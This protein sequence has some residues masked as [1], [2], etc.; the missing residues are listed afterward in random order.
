MNKLVSVIGPSCA[1]VLAAN[2]PQVS[3]SKVVVV[4]VV[5]VEADQWLWWPIEDLGDAKKSAP[6]NLFPYIQKKSFLG[7]FNK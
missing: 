6:S 2:G 7:W 1:R 3:A 4:V 5:V